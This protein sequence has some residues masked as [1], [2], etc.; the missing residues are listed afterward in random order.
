MFDKLSVFFNY[1]FLLIPDGMK[2]LFRKNMLRIM[3][4]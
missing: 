3:L 2:W 1:F 4:R